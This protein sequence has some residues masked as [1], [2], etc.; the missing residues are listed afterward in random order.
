MRGLKVNSAIALVSGLKGCLCEKWEGIKNGTRRF[1]CRLYVDFFNR[2]GIT[3]RDLMISPQLFEHR[4]VQ[5]I[6]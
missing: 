5:V 4:L 6:P 2:D 1:L 3:R